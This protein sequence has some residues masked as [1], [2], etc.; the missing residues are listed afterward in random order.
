MLGGMLCVVRQ[1]CSLYWTIGRAQT[2][3]LTHTSVV[4]FNWFLESNSRKPASHVVGKN[5]R[6]GWRGLQTL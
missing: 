2:V 5:L 4:Q 1:A 6:D 3:S